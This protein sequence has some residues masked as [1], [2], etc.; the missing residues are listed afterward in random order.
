MPDVIQ[1][2]DFYFNIDD[3]LGGV[4]TL[5]PPNKGGVNFLVSGQNVIIKESGVVTR[6]SGI[7]KIGSIDLGYVGS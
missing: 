5:I 2:E 1:E 3:F 6:R 4:N 7:S